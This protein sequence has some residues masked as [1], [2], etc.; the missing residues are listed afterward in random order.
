M[1]MLAISFTNLT[2]LLPIAQASCP[3]LNFVFCYCKNDVL[4][5]QNVFL[6]LVQSG[7]MFL[8]LYQQKKSYYYHGVVRS[9]VTTTMIEHVT[10]IKYIIVMEPLFS[11]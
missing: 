10:F 1:N 3:L 5:W 2:I 7:L 9:S 8:M 6:N 4:F 11:L